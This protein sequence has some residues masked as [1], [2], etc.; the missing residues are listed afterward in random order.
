MLLVGISEELIAR[1]LVLSFAHEAF[2]SD[3]KKGA[4][5]TAA[6]SGIVFGC[7]H[8]LNLFGSSDKGAVLIQ[9]FAT[10]CTGF[11]WG[12]LFLRKRNIFALMLMHALSDI[13]VLLSK[14]FATGQADTRSVIE[15][16]NAFVLI[17]A[18]I[19][20]VAGIYVLRDEKM[21]YS[22]EKAVTVYPSAV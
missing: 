2:G 12:T 7:L 6:I 15:S 21:H 18:A 13:V 22:S 16:T 4:C 19:Y 1:G 17:L 20:V 14:G 11:Y 9:V 3:T 5:L 8:L 10:A